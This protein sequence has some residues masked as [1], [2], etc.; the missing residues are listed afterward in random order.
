MKILDKYYKVTREFEERLPTDPGEETRQSIEENQKLID[1]CKEDFLPNKK[2]DDI[3]VKAEKMKKYV[4]PVVPKH[5]KESIFQRKRIC[6]QRPTASRI[7][8][9]EL[10]SKTQN[11]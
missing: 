7:I 6:Q 2:A 11:E 1:W 3:Q 5:T 9:N 4:E 8:K 10:I